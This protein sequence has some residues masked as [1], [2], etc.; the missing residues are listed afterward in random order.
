MQ[1]DGKVAFITGAAQVR[2]ART[3]FGSP[4]RARTS[5]RSIC[6]IRLTPSPIRWA[7]DLQRL[8]RL[9]ADRQQPH[10]LNADVA[11][12]GERA[13]LQLRRNR[14]HAYVQRLPAVL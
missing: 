13:S 2:A 12:I 1:F 5:S 4:K 3:R 9:R 14:C 10:G 11:D 6:A 8:G 7:A